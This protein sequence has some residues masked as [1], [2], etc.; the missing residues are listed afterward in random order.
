MNSIEWTKYY[1]RLNAFASKASDAVLVVS[2]GD[3]NLAGRAYSNVL[4]RYK[5]Y[6][7]GMNGKGQNVYFCFSLFRDEENLFWSWRETHGKTKM[8]RD[9]YSHRR[10]K[11]ACKEIAR[12]RYNAFIDKYGHAET[13][14]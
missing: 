1:K 7:A 10:K 6:D 2:D 5:W 9:M 8:K 13:V 3:R 14:V 11:A 12:K 4:M